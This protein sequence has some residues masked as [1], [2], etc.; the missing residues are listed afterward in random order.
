MLFATAVAAEVLT[1]PRDSCDC[2]PTNV[3]R[4]PRLLVFAHVNVA[5]GIIWAHLID[6]AELDNMLAMAENV[7]PKTE[8]EIGR[9]GGER[10]R[11]CCHLRA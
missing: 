3:F 1:Q 11:P 5:A 4:Q 7:A 8:T 10:E 6:R 9:T 2:Y